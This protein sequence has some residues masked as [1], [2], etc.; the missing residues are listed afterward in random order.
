[1]VNTVLSETANILKVKLQGVVWWF[2]LEWF[3]DFFVPEQ[4]YNE[5]AKLKKITSTHIDIYST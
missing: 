5:I 3:V 1:M 2:F 4:M